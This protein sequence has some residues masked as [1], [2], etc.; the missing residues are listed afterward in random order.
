MSVYFKKKP[1][2]VM[3]EVTEEINPILFQKCQETIIGLESLNHSIR[4]LQELTIAVVESESEVL[5]Y[6]LRKEH[7]NEDYKKLKKTIS[8]MVDLKMSMSS[9]IAK[10]DNGKIKFFDYLNEIKISLPV[11]LQ[12]KTVKKLKKLCQ[13]HHVSNLL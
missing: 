10:R 7:T 5:E 1:D 12:E 9:L 13:N 11:K 2:V 6:C 3:T 4:R 8:L